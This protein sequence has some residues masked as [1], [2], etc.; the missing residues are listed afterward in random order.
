MAAENP[1]AIT[2]YLGRKPEAVGA[3]DALARECG[4]RVFESH[5]FR[6][7]IPHDS[8]CFAGFEPGPA[9]AD[10]DVGLLADV[11]VPWLPKFAKESP[12]TRWIQVD[13]DAIKAGFP[14]WGFPTEVRVQGDCA[15]VLGQVLEIVRAEGSAAFRSAV[16]GRMKKMETQRQLRAESPAAAAARPGERGAITPDFLC[17]AL[18]KVIGPDDRISARMAETAP[19]W[20]MGATSACRALLGIVF[21]AYKKEGLTYLLGYGK[22]R[23]KT[24]KDEGLREAKNRVQWGPLTHSQP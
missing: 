11:D 13:I 18:N 14:L 12:R 20:P 2:S 9:I 19:G 21:L 6:L 8:P 16:A 5:P 10:A 15:T 24:L 17:A 4:M 7:N 3:L 1:V 23:L 22:S